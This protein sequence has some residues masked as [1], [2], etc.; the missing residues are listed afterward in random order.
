MPSNYSDCCQDYRI[1]I[2][3]FVFLT[4]LSLEIARDQAFI[5]HLFEL[6]QSCPQLI[7]QFSSKNTF[8]QSVLVGVKNTFLHYIRA[9]FTT[10]ILFK[11]LYGSFFLG[12]ERGSAWQ[13]LRSAVVS[14]Q[15]STDKLLESSLPPIECF[16][17]KLRN[18]QPSV[19]E[20]K[21]ALDGT[22]NYRT[23]LMSKMQMELLNYVRLHS[24]MTLRCREGILTT[25]GIDL[26]DLQRRACLGGCFGTVSVL[27]L[28]RS[29]Y[30]GV[31]CLVLSL[32]TL[33][34]K[35]ETRQTNL[36]LDCLETVLALF[37][38]FSRDTGNEPFASTKSREGGNQRC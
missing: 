18:S 25:K 27:T 12:N 11:L 9:K 22:T 23:L 14:I 1:S 6:L 32:T 38:L 34:D 26:T 35:T 33:Q 8:S 30:K 31:T 7:I 16:C 4:Y 13:K 17:N 15:S 10:I 5:S 36:V 20:Y 19:T 24:V 29:Q 37:F 3:P 21:H 28:R 2:E